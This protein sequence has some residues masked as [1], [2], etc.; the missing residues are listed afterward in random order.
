MH[1]FVAFTRFFLDYDD[2]E[3]DTANA[4]HAPTGV[5]GGELTPIAEEEGTVVIQVAL[6]I[7]AGSRLCWPEKAAHKTWVRSCGVAV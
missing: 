4:H 6:S 5:T 2:V 1:K 3:A 7:S